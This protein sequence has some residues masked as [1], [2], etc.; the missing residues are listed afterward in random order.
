MSEAEQ[1]AQFGV[2]VV[3][4]AVVSVTTLTVKAVQEDRVPM[5][6][7]ASTALTL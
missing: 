7:R 5:F 1:V 3:V 4:G 2:M 6:Q